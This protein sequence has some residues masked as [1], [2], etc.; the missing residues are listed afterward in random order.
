MSN[1]SNN[2]GSTTRTTKS[3]KGPKPIVSVAELRK[4]MNDE[5][6]RL[7][8]E[9]DDAMVLIETIA[10]DVSRLSTRPAAIIKFSDLVDQI[11]E[12]AD[13][14]RKILDNKQNTDDR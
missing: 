8:A 9:R 12:W 2:N 6:E 3:R 1:K 4:R 10:R 7:R 11:N 14:A 13:A 5:I